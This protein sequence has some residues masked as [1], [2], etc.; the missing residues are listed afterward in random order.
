MSKKEETCGEAIERITK[1]LL[2]GEGVTD[3]DAKLLEN[4]AT[5]TM[6]TIKNPDYIKDLLERKDWEKQMEKMFNNS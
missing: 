5:L 6:K 1:K 3:K 2:K 4:F